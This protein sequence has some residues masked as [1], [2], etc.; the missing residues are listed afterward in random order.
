MKLYLFHP[1][2]KEYLKTVKAKVDLLKSTADNLVYVIPENATPVAPLK[3]ARNETCIF[4]G[5]WEVVKDYRGSRYFDT[6][7]NRIV[8]VTKL[9]EIPSY[10]LSLDS[11]EFQN[12][13]QHDE[14]TY[15]KVLEE[16]INKFH[17]QQ[18]ETEILIGKYYFK[19]KDY[20]SLLYLYQNSLLK[21]ENIKAQ[22][23]IANEAT[24]NDEDLINDLLHQLEQLQWITLAVKNK[25]RKK[26]RTEFQLNEVAQIL[27]K[28]KTMTKELQYKKSKYLTK[29]L[30]L[31][32]YELA[33]FEQ[34]IKRGLENEE[35][36]NETLLK[37][38]SKTN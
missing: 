25:R 7:A 2:T 26:I 33:L 20:P 36:G 9:G 28:L 37:E 6:K 35:K 3:T 34:R 38:A 10:Y 24:I 19:P 23:S 30:S 29:L 16:Q 31:K 11:K 14:A 22:L 18:L 8:E 15:K 17:E 12:Y 1:K 21:I 5:K 32:G 27:T 13:I 4:N